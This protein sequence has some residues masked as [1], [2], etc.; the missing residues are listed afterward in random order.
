MNTWNRKVHVIRKMHLHE[1]DLQDLIKFE[2]AETV[3]MNGPLFS[4]ET[5]HEYTKHPEK[6]TM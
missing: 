4:R 5:L 1:P 2:E 6:S 3:L